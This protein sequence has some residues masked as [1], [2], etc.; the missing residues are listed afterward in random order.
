MSLASTY[1]YRRCR[2]VAHRWDIVDTNDWTVDPAKL[3]FALPMQLRCDNCDMVRR[4]LVEKGT[5]D[6]ISRRYIPPKGYYFARGETPTRAE[7]RK[8]WLDDQIAKVREERRAR[9]QKE[10]TV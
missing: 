7:F 6:V 3:R 8:A 4:D 9:R 1:T 5:G 10:T 2:L